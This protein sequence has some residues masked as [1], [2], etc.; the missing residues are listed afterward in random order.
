V[1]LFKIIL[2]IIKTMSWSECPHFYINESMNDVVIKN[3]SI[4]S[5]NIASYDEINDKDEFEI[6]I[7]KINNN[8]KIQD[9]F[10]NYN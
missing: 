1:Q 8:Y 5:N 7:D 6:V 4:K 9:I 2:L 3:V 10:Y